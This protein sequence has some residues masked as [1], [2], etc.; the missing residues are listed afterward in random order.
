MARSFSRAI[1]PLSLNSR[2]PYVSPCAF[3]LRVRCPFPFPDLPIDCRN[4]I[5]SVTRLGAGVTRGFRR[6]GLAP[7]CDTGASV[8]LARVMPRDLSSFVQLR[9]S[10]PSRS[11]R[12]G[13]LSPARRDRDPARAHDA[14]RKEEMKHPPTTVMAGDQPKSRAMR[15]KRR[16]KFA[17]KVAGFAACSKECGGGMEPDN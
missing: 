7:P 6:L 4:R 10:L 11:D 9:C 5:I 8:P 17:W 13:D 1:G 14:G 3:A 2:F 12:R 16:R 15:K